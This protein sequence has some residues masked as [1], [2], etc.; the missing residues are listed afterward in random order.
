M[1]LAPKDV[2]EKL[3][4]D[5]VINLLAEE[6]AGD[7]GR[8]KV[9]SLHPQTNKDVIEGQ[10]QEAEQFRDS[11]ERRELF[12]MNTYHDLSQDLRLLEVE[13]SVLGEKGLQRIN[14]Q[15][16]ATRAI[17]KF[18][19]ESRRASYP[20]LYD[21]VRTV[22]FD[23]ILIK[24]I[25]SVIDE[26]GEIRSDASPELMR[27]RKLTNSKYKELDKAFRNVINTYRSKGWLSEN[28]ES[29]RNGRRILSVPAEHK[30]KVRGIIHDESA[31]G[32]TAFIEPEAV[33]Q[34]NN[35]IFDLAQEEKR[36]LY[37]ILKTLSAVLRPYTPA[38]YNYQGI[39]VRFDVIQAKARLAL[40]MKATRPKLHPRP[41]FKILEGRHP[42]LF[43]KNSSLKK[44]TVPFD[45]EFFGSNRILMLSGPNAGG[46]SI[47][48][49]AV[50]LLQLML[51][52][53]LLI[54][55]DE[56]SELGIFS[57]V[58]ADIGD[59]QSIEDDLSTYS[60]RLA[61]MREFMELSNEETLILIDEFGSGTDPKIGG[62]IAEAILKD[63]NDRKM[64]GLITT[65]YSNLKIFAFKT[66]GIVNASMHFDKDTLSPTYELKV[67]RPGSS[68]AFEIAQKSGL[69]AKV[70]KY[71]KHRTGKSEKA[72]DQLL[73][74]LQREKQELEEELATLR[75]RQKQL[76]RLVKNY[77]HMQREMEFRRKKL[78]LETKEQALQ[79]AAHLNRDYEKLIRELR[80]AQKLEEAKKVAEQVREERKQLQE[81]VQELREK[82]YF[83]PTSKKVEE[84]PVAVGDFVRLRSGGATGTVEAIEK[85]KAVVQMGLMRMTVKLRDLT[86]ANAPLEVRNSQ[87]I[88]M[89]TSGPAT[90]FQKKIDIRGMR[91][92]EALQV[93]EEFMD[94]AL[95]NSSSLLE[96]VHGKGTGVLRQAVRKKLREYNV[97]MDIRHPA[98]E[99][100]GD[101]VTLVEFM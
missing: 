26:E 40:R 89:E 57:Q 63:L 3:E 91:Y 25:E 19:T 75:N 31:T 66:K 48:M 24:E 97:E 30:R 85:N 36:E 21:I 49:K 76:D 69:P 8:E 34:I 28:V 70:L 83:E 64:F 6:C 99:Q 15:L 9:L 14:V 56:E 59:Q 74:D 77:E 10:L 100:G 90:D 39:L 16:R 11:I 94:Q 5:K 60:S 27:I 101:G 47:T 84:R 4:F 61:N 62:A 78:K 44:K 87:S 68:Y 65:H 23:P 38:L 17:F 29:F 88:R 7:L 45:L 35:D 52:T 2:L 73:I 67:G 37:R 18:F 71:A 96:I 54:P 95:L 41:F 79:E 53:G 92:E 72:V 33:I 42:L 22:H 93:V 46:K 32:R 82:V 80:E 58:F 1:R 86:L 51:Q 50:G 98:P 20:A 13:N 12:P 55:A 81:E 43:L